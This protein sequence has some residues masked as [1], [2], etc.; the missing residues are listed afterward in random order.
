MKSKLFVP[1]SRPELF[2]KALASQAD[3]ISF[4]LED[5]VPETRKAEARIALRAL[6]LAPGLARNGNGGNGKTLIV[7][8]NAFESRHFQ[9]DIAAVV[10][11]GVDLINLPKLRNA[12]DVRAAGEWRRYADRAVAQY[13]IAGCVAWRV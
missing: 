12:A 7:R 6:L 13:R 11:S 10:Q 2:V 3:A 1:A 9:D 4:D 5:A 8:V